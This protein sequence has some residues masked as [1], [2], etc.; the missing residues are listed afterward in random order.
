MNLKP[1]DVGLLL[2]RMVV[3]RIDPDAVDR[4]DPLLYRELQG[5]CSLCRSKGRCAR[6]L[7]HDA[8]DRASQSWKEYCPN[9]TTLNRLAQGASRIPDLWQVLQPLR[10]AQS[11]TQLAGFCQVNL[12]LGFGIFNLLAM[13]AVFVF[14]GAVLLGAF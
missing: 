6:D 9:G 1:A 5:L 11:G 13:Y 7:A 8:A 2:N 10:V 14:L 12:P 4:A 3:L